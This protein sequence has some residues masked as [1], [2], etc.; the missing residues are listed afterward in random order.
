MPFTSLTRAIAP[1]RPRRHHA[2]DHPGPPL[3]RHRAPAPSKPGGGLGLLAQARLHQLRRSRRTDRHD[4]PRT[5]G[6]A[7]LDLRAPLSACAQLLHVAA[8]ARGDPVGHLH[9]LAASRRARCPGRRGALLP[10]RLRPAVGAGGRL[11]RLRRRPRGAGDLLRDQARSGR[12][13]PVRRLAHRLA[14]AQE[15]GADGHRS[16]GLRRHLCLRDRLPLDR[17]RRRHPGCHRRPADAR[18]VPRR[19][20]A[21]GAPRSAMG[22][23]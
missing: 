15:R 11:S 18:Q 21:T 20:T 10:A 2:D 17:A 1:D 3:A 9:Q 23:R 4:A 14:G 7:P 8:R 6:E 19:R 13:G 12:R 22:R 5:G 16:P